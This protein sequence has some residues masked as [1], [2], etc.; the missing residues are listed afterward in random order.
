MTRSD[1]MQK[2]LHIRLIDHK[3]P[4]L[5]AAFSAAKVGVYRITENKQSLEEDF[6]KWTGGNR[7]A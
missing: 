7:I 5:V 3:V 6:L 4:E 1:E 2:E